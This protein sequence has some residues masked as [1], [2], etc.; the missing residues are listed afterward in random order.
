MGAHAEDLQEDES[1]KMSGW[2]VNDRAERLGT[3]EWDVDMS[4]ITDEGS[5][6]LHHT[7]Q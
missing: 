2:E 5:A 1:Y 3:K 7:P 6:E 4:S